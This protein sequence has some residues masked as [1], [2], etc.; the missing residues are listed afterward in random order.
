LDGETD[1]KLRVA[2]PYTQNLIED[3]LILDLNCEVYAEK[4]QK[5]IHAFVGTYRV[6]FNYLKLLYIDLR[7]MLKIVRM[8]V[9]CL[10]KMFFGQTLFWLVGQLLV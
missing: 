4:P 6:F 1:W 8:M 2:V 10:S 3:C 5:D 7:S 9:L